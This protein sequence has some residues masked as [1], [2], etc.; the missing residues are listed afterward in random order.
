[1]VS[2]RE[3]RMLFLIPY[4]HTY[5]SN[6]FM[7]RFLFVASSPSDHCRSRN[8]YDSEIGYTLGAYSICLRQRMISYRKN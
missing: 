6:S 3:H 2:D 4:R 5:M 7:V 8:F 1:M